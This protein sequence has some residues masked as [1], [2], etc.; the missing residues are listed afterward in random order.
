MLHGRVTEQ[1]QG[2]EYCDYGGSDLDDDL[3]HSVEHGVRC[4]QLAKW[5]GGHCYTCGSAGNCNAL[6]RLRFS[7]ASRE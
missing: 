2:E 1:V 6:R 5:P 3:G 7:S 4:K